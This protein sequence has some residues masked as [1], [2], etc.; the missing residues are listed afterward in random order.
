MKTTQLQDLNEKELKLLHNGEYQATLSLAEWAH[1]CRKLLRLASNYQIVKER[2]QYVLLRVVLILLL[3][4]YTVIS[5]GDT[6]PVF[7]TD[8]MYHSVIGRGLMGILAVSYLF[9]VGLT[10]YKLRIL[11][12]RKKRLHVNNRFFETIITEMPEKLQEMVSPNIPLT[13]KIQMK[14]DFGANSASLNPATNRYE[15][16]HLQAQAVLAKGV[17]CQYSLVIHY[18]KIRYWKKGR[19]NSSKLKRKT[20]ARSYF[21]LKLQVKQHLFDKK[22][23]AGLVGKAKI[24]KRGDKVI[25][26][27][28]FQR[29]SKAETVVSNASITTMV[30]Q[31]PINQLKFILRQLDLLT[32]VKEK[33]EEQK[34][35]KTFTAADYEGFEEAVLQQEVAEAL[36]EDAFGDS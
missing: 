36:V 25:I 13:Q 4:G 24:I 21:L 34:M 26:K 3:G 5:I 31:D 27:S 20:K 18:H 8:F 33:S 15:I 35:D 6:L 29:K 12:G 9:L 11:P 16:E 14:G 2:E 30:A 32:Y 17:V 19:G 22:R 7:Y 10:F 23:L 28:L 1:S